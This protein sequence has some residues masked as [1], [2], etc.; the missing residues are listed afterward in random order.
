MGG[1]R[2]AA[3]VVIAMAVV[4]LTGCGSGSSG[5][6]ELS[7]LQATNE[8]RFKPDQFKVRL[9]QETVFTLQNT[10]KS[11]THNF[12]LSSVFTDPDHFV[13]VDVPAGQSRQVK[14]TVTQRPGPGY[15][16]FYCRFHQG[17]GM[18]G[19]ITLA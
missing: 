16:T 9:N 19:R 13:S 4:G 18:A 2:V 7:V 11:R 8:L 10:D 15:F 14:F 1:R 6:K 3:A 12:T 5:P 17:D